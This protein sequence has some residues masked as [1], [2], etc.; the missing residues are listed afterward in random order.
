MFNRFKYPLQTD[1]FTLLDRLKVALFVLNKRNR[2]TFGPKVI[3][4]EETWENIAKSK[5]VATS[6]GSTANS[7][8]FET[9]LQTHN[10]D[11]KNITVFCP[12]T[13]WASSVTPI[14]MRGMEVKFVDINLTD[15][16]FDYAKL[17]QELK[18]RENDG[19]I[20]VIWPTALIGFIPDI[21]RLR[22]L[23]KEFGAYL[24]ADLCEC[25]IGEYKGHNIL[26][27]FDMATTS[28]FWAHQLTAIEFGILFIKPELE[29][30]YHNALSIRSHGLT[31]VLPIKLRESIEKHH[32]N[33]D[34]EFLF[35]KIGTN[36]RNTDI[37]AMFGLL[38]TKRLDF[39]TKFRKD[40]WRY[41]LD[42]LPNHFRPLNREIVPFCLPFVLKENNPK[43]IKSIKNILNENGW[44]TRPIIC[45]LPI[46]PAFVKYGSGDVYENSRFLNNNGF[47]VGL[48]KDLK[49][50]DIDKLLNLVK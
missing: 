10:Y 34:K 21:D 17:A 8:L 3:Q 1:N 44:E 12:S 49:T 43:Y 27:C 25:T 15:F 46:N 16:S 23:A 47:Y 30:E 29:K 35:D 20:K 14:I 50:K 45:Y 19:K 7:L 13:T 42:R 11:P 22:G 5:C 41:F 2:L 36:W 4:L 31:R 40:L 38:D 24:F 6:S 18:T 9:F 39:Y 32:P 33:I 48:N 26:N 37:H 28:F